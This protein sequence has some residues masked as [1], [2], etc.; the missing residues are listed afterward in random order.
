MTVSRKVKI[1]VLIGGGGRLPAIYRGTQAADS[2]AELALVV[3]FKR[4]S[5]GLEWA[6]EQNLAATYLR[7]VDFKKKGHTRQEF[8]AALSQLLR[9]YQIELIV[10]AGWGLLL[11][12]EFF[13]DWQNRIIN[14]H[15]ALLT[16]T[17]E[18]KVR[19]ENGHFI[20]V[21]RGNDAIE[22][23]LAAGVNCTGCTVHYVTTVMDTGPIIIKKE[24]P[25][26]HNDSLENLTNR[27]H[28]AEDEILPIAIEKISRTI[29]DGQN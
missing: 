27:I 13:K 21:F 28:K 3:S 5:T 1:A 9:E 4:A 10:L 17:F 8:D 16:P 22:L 15:P 11:T 25:I 23:A 7:W 12:A 29:L 20:P 6:K 24:V 18:K 14:I 19:L 2:S 26:Y